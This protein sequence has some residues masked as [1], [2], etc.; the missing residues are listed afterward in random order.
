MLQHMAKAQVL[1]LVLRG[2]DLAVAVVEVALD[3]ERARVARLVG[4]GVV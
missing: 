2:V 4:R 3:H 1:D